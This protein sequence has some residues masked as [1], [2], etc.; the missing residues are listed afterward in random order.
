MTVATAAQAEILPPGNRAVPLGVHALVG[1]KVVIKPGETLDSATIVIRDGLIEKVGKDVAAPPDARVWDMKGTTIYAGFIDPYLT[2]ASAAATNAAPTRGRFGGLPPQNQNLTAGRFYGLAVAEL[3]PGAPGP[4][5]QLSVIVPEHRAVEGLAP[6]A[7]A[8]QSLRGAGFTAGNVVPS[9]GI[10]KGTSAFISLGESNPND[11]VIRAD[12]FQHIALE[13]GG[14]FGG[15]YPSSLM[16]IISAIR[17]TMY[18]AQ[19]DA[20][21]HAAYEKSPL[22]HK[23][24]AFNPASKALEP[25][26]D[27]KMTVVFEP[28]SALMVDRATRLAQEFGL[29]YYILAS[30]QEWRRPELAKSA[31][32]PFILPLSYPEIT[33]MSHDDDWNSINL[34]QLRA[35]DWAPEDAAVL[36]SNNLEVALTTY[37]LDDKSAFHRNLVAAIDR[38]Y[39]ESDALAGLTTIPAKLCGVDKSLGTI[40]VGKM[41]DLTVVTGKGYFDPDAKVKEVWIRS[42]ERR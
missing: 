20:L 40:E 32:V 39:S 36:R 9:T 13:S 19:H 3:D 33:K 7:S 17:Q 21:E 27:K 23:R 28:G 29:N 24:P 42:E 2:I 41:A 5:S 38:G 4:S 37:E 26:L 16:G 14:G 1:G 15:G 30:G 18:D 34:D 12:V 25:A 6:E 35:W 22:G 11:A 31:G 10:I 8:L